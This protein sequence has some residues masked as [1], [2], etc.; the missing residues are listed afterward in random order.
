MINYIRSMFGRRKSPY[1]IEPF[2]DVL[3]RPRWRIVHDNGEILASSE[4]YTSAQKRDQTIE[5]LSEW[6]GIRIVSK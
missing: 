6:H 4:D 2:M 5:N 1:R 3:G